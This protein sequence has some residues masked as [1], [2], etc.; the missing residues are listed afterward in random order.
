MIKC[1]LKDINKDEKLSLKGEKIETLYDEYYKEGD[2][3]HISCDSDFILASFDDSQVKSIIYIPDHEFT[4]PVPCGG[5]LDA[6]DRES[7]E[8]KGHKILLEEISDEDAFGTRNIA[9]NSID[10]TLNQKTFPHATAN[11][12]T[13][14]SACFEAKNAIDGIC[15]N[16]EHGEYPFHSWAAGARE[17]II[18][19]VD[20]GCE[21]EI[22][23]LTFYLRA[24]FPHDTYWKSLNVKFS[25]GEKAHAEFEMTKD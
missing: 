12:V 18:Y 14:G 8:K 5:A 4:Y 3:F 21:V 7:W 16:E 17:D 10:F 1:I 15:R 25:D 11:F 2:T 9:L 13:R 22:E 20:F 24:D 6:Y 23:K 19:T